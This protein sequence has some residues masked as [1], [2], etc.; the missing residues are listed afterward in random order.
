[1]ASNWTDISAIVREMRMMAGD[2]KRELEEVNNSFELDAAIG[3]LINN[4]SEVHGR[5]TTVLKEALFQREL[6]DRS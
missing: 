6:N 2:V 1:M 4:M 3:P 5:L